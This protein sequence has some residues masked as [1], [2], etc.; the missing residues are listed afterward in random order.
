MTYIDE[1]EVAEAL[2]EDSSFIAPYLDYA[3]SQ[4]D[5]HILLHLGNALSLLSV[6]APKDMGI[7]LWGTIHKPNIY[8]LLVAKSSDGRKTTSIK[9]AT[10]LLQEALIYRTSGGNEDP[11]LVSWNPLA[12]Q[13]GS[14]Q[15]LLDSFKDKPEQLLVYEEMGQFLEQSAGTSD[16]N[17]FAMMRGAFTEAYDSG[18]IG[19]VTKK[20]GNRTQASGHRLVILGASNLAFLR[21]TTNADDWK[22]GFLAR[23]HVFNVDDTYYDSPLRRR[24]D[25]SDENEAARLHLNAT[26]HSMLS[27]KR[28]ADL[29]KTRQIYHPCTGL[30]AD[31]KK[32]FSA[33]REEKERRKLAAN[34]I[35]QASFARADQLI[36]KIAML[37]AV[38]NGKI[39][40]TSWQVTEREMLPAVKI[41]QL[42]LTALEQLGKAI[43]QRASKE[44][45][46][47]VR[48]REA[49]RLAGPAGIKLGDVSEQVRMVIDNKF[50]V[51]ISTLKEQ[52]KI[53][54]EGAFLVWCE[55]EES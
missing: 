11:N 55:E 18:R 39:W 33:F 53:K 26:Y 45:D 22:T 5:A 20:A 9:M 44:W 30:D 14:P 54:N 23:F 7:S 51:L 28:G 52:K 49:I 42:H 47:L 12:D 34:E 29:Q 15:V 48:V 6:A 24:R 36:L 17:P 16:R 41:L 27:M 1:A 21:R 2:P 50:R 25:E 13:A 4:N 38:E 32:I 43:D 19:R 31:A 46:D 10:R 37:L 35:L 8:S 3:M 40:L